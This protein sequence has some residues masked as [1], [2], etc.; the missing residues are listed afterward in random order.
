MASTA[1]GVY[2]CTHAWWGA[3]GPADDPF[4][5]DQSV[6]SRS[7][8]RI[9]SVAAEQQWHS[10]ERWRIQQRREGAH[11]HAYATY[12][13]LKDYAER[14]NIEV[15]RQRAMAEDNYRATIERG[16]PQERAMRWAQWEA[17]TGNFT[18]AAERLLEAQQLEAGDASAMYILNDIASCL[19]ATGDRA[20]AEPFARDFERRRILIEANQMS[21]S[22][23]AFCDFVTVPAQTHRG[24]DIG[25]TP[26]HG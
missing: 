14:G 15:Q 18:T 8:Q 19:L 23:E 6:L 10:D 24:V 11:P 17:E 21:R 26:P 3:D 2:V 4:S 16:L 1:D 13:E 12:S 7:R 22:A 20:R 9:L 25:P 5:A